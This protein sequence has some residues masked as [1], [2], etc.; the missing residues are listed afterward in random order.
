LILTADADEARAKRRVRSSIVI[1][2]EWKFVR[3]G[4]KYDYESIRADDLSD[5]PREVRT[6][7]VF[8]SYSPIP[9]TILCYQF[10]EIWTSS[11]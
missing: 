4:Q 2:V 11:Q 9:S 6:M 3:R 5:E 8:I 1:I 7:K 10:V